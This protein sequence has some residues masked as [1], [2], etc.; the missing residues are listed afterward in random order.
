[1]IF[2]NGKYR[3]ET[4]AELKAVHEIP[5]EIKIAELK[6]NLR[7][8]DEMALHFVEGILTA[9]EYEPIKQQRKEWLDEIKRLES[10]V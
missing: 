4:A 7:D 10:G 3:K 8:T 5:T 1:M 2:E 6:Q 9:E